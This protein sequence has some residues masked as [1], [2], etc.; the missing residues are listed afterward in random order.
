[1]KIF[2]EKAVDILHKELGEVLISKCF[3]NDMYYFFSVQ[4][5]LPLNIEEAF[6]TCTLYS[7][8]KENGEFNQL[9]FTHWNRE[10]QDNLIIDD[11]PDEIDYSE[12]EEESAPIS[13]IVFFELL[14]QEGFS[15]EVVG[16]DYYEATQIVIPRYMLPNN[17]HDIP[18]GGGIHYYDLNLKKWDMM[19]FL[20]LCEH[21]GSKTVRFD[22]FVQSD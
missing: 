13:R 16:Y 20:E 21:L 12:M 8:R 9:D 11:Y 4:P 6:H 14:K 3:E 5:E 18:T 17:P 15:R 2:F 22:C 10:E 19:N 1:M 7:V